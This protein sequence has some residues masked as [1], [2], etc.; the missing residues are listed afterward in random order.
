MIKDL[1]ANIYELWGAAYLDKFSTYMY[2]ADLYSN[3]F[4]WMLLIT[5][6]I[7]FAYYKLDRINTDKVSVW[8][9][10]TIGASLICAAVAYAV[11]MNGIDDYLFDHKIKDTSISVND[12]LIFTLIAFGWSFVLSFIWSILFKYSSTILRRTPF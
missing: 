7:V 12:G 3:V 11:S 1:I 4:V 8:L 6:L 10:V 9:L 2:K 5:L